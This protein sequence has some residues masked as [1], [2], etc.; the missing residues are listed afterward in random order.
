AGPGLAQFRGAF[1]GDSAIAGCFHQRCMQ[2]PFELKRYEP[3]TAQQPSND[4]VP[5]KTSEIL[6]DSEL[7]GDWKGA[8]QT[9]E[10]LLIKTHFKKQNGELKGTIE[11]QNVELPLQNIEVMNDD[12]LHFE[13]GSQNGLATFKGLFTSDSSIAGNFIQN[14]FT[15]PFQLHRFEPDTVAKQA[16]KTPLPYH[17]KDIIIKNDTIA[18]GGTLTWPKDKKAKQL[19]IMI[20]G[21]G[22]QNRDEELF[23]FK[24][25]AQIT[26]YLTRHDIATF[27]FD[28][29]GIGESGGDPN[30]GLDVL[31]EDVRAIYTSL[32][33]RPELSQASIGLLGHSQGGYIAN[34]LAAKNTHFDFIILMS[35]PSFPLDKIIFQQTEAIEKASGTPDS[36]I[37]KGLQ[38]QREFFS[39]MREDKL[40]SLRKARINET[41]TQLAKLPDKKKQH[42]EDVHSY[43]SQKV[44]QQIAQLSLPIFQSMIAYDP[45]Q[46][47]QNIQIPVLALF[48]EKDLQ[49]LPEPN[50]RRLRKALEK[51]GADYKIKIFDDANHLY[52]KAKKGL[53]SEY[54]SLDKK[55]VDDF[56]PTITQ[57]VK[58]Q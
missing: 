3:K 56:L 35:G 54:G 30:V 38:N 44:N 10:P 26:D 23:G 11:I 41:E 31:A 18:I 58:K 51:S 17:H 19:V 1:Q 39:A 7:A 8:I 6:R 46:D 29:R 55:F 33:D 9:N 22:A 47:T 53:P 27:R 2:F 49:V 16:T 13:F 25:F 50:A 20:S 42:I 45:M 34:K 28:D 14:S 57:W 24:P 37:Q 21:S 48:G 5:I 36:V 43:A 52:Q 15:F 32:N 40:D 4:K 12:S